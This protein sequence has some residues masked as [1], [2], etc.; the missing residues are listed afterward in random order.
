MQQAGIHGIVDAVCFLMP[1]AEAF[2]RG[3]CLY[4][5]VQPFMVSPVMSNGACSCEDVKAFR[6]G[7]KKVAACGGAAYFLTMLLLYT[8]HISMDVYIIYGMAS[9][10]MFFVICWMDQ[11]NYRQ[12]FFLVTTF[13]AL[14]LL[15]AS[16]A[17]ILYDFLYYSALRTDFMRNHEQMGS[18]LY[19]FMCLLDLVMEI[20]LTAIGTW[21]VVRIYVD[22]AK[23]MEK[24]E[25]AMLALPSCMGVIGYE[26]MRYYRVFYALRTGDM[27]WTYDGLMLLYCVVS[28]ITVIVVILLYQDMKAKQEENQQAKLLG[29]QI[30]SLRQHMEQVE[31]LYQNIRSLKHDMTNHILT[32]ERLYEENQAEEARAYS[33]C[34]KTEL[35]QMA[36]EFETGNPVTN[37]ILQEF[38]R[39]AGKRGI[40]FESEFHYPAG[41]NI[42]VFDVSIILHNALQNAVENTDKGKR[43]SI[44]SYRRNNACIME[45]CNSFGKNLQWDAERG[46]PVTSKEETDGH[47][48]GLPN[49]RRVAGKYAGD[50]DIVLKDGE[51][52]LCVMLMME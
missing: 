13:F 29:T 27:E 21:Q 41:S 39:E 17:E 50:I 34:L 18:G 7:K 51:F 28:S 46:L 16:I 42:D 15:A 35:A 12:K 6:T 49:I 19:I 25:V 8:L 36:G 3:Y 30:V 47:G 52:C 1:L 10:A 22:K 45:I 4:R 38:A 40:L 14:N 23:E 44:I 31:G 2:A 20:V 32:M 24:K 11:R 37:V 43:I 33:D 48:Y 9:L 26:I 5:F